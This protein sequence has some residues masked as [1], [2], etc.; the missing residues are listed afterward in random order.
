MEEKC[1]TM[2]MY[3][4]MIWMY[5]NSVRDW[6]NVGKNAKGI[7][8]NFLKWERM[9]VRSHLDYCWRRPAPYS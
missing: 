3:R 7:K 6:L 4:G 9:Q 2:K 5:I 1:S 8:Y